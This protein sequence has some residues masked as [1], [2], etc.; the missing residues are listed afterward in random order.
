MKALVLS[1]G[2]GTR[3]RPITHTS[4]KQ[5]V[6]VANKPIL[7]HAL[8]AIASA[9]ITDVTIVVGDTA[10]EV[11]RAVADG[12]RFG[13]TVE[14]VRQRRPLGLAHAVLIARDALGE[15]D[16]VMY[17][18]DNFVD[19]DV[20][21]ITRQFGQ[22]GL[23]V[24]VLLARVPNPSSFGVAEVDADNRVIMLAEKPARPRSSLALVGIYVFSPIVHEAVRHLSPSS[25]GELE[26]T[27]AIQWMVSSGAV[28]GAQLTCEFWRD[29]GTVAGVLDVNRVVLERIAPRLDGSVDAASTIRGNV[30]VEPGALVRNSYVAGPAII[31]SGCVISDS[32]IGPAT[33]VAAQCRIESSRIES[34][35]V[36]PGAFIS[37]IAFIERSLI[38]RNVRLTSS[39]NGPRAHRLVLGDHCKLELPV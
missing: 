23:A 32:F 37:G 18:G 11:R 8:E 22:D 19:H 30:I 33:S 27:D 36:F 16:F 15:D 5:L 3:L 29:A 17:L 13:L 10:D 25:R 34:S 24:R 12:G 20:A 35:I 28:V 7:F 21:T 2:C 38:G 26:I 39:R 31:G 1:G 14:Y 4:A 6:P 9:G